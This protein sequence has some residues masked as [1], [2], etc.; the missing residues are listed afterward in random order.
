MKTCTKCRLTKPLSE[1]YRDRS[2]N[3][4]RPYCRICD[5]T[6]IVLI[7]HRFKE[8]MVFYKGGSCMKCGYAKNIAA[9]DFHHRDP[10]QKSFAVG[11]FRSLR[12][13]TWK[14]IA[15]ELDKCDLL[16]ANCHREEHNPLSQLS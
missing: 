14:E 2:K 7:Q 8:K 3:G 10:R 11:K 16:C 12:G 5:K 1:F 6:R 4:Y 13:R 15:R 9:L